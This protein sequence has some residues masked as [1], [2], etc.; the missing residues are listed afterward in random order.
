MSARPRANVRSQLDEQVFRA[1]GGA[2]DQVV[3][4]RR[5]SQT[6]TG[7]APAAVERGDRAG[8]DRSCRERSSS[9]TAHV[10]GRPPR[11]PRAYRGFSTLPWRPCVH[12][13]SSAPA[14][15]VL[16]DLG[17]WA[18]RS[19]AE[20]K[21]DRGRDGRALAGHPRRAS[22]A[23]QSVS[24]ASSNP[25]LHPPRMSWREERHTERRTRRCRGP[26]PAIESANWT[27]GQTA[28]PH[29][30]TRMARSVAVASITA[31]ASSADWSPAYGLR[32]GW[33]VGSSVPS[34]SRR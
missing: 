18:R 3:E 14:H 8:S 12:G 9:G 29:G 31:R 16:E 33:T 11:P 19:L 21:P 10:R 5:R 34:P 30:P 23:L 28:S 15:D 26:G 25:V 32:L 2:P 4:G 27:A 20:E 17:E 24:D 22:P 13:P 7:R 1:P 6:T